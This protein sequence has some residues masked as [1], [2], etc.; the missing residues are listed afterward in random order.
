VH[1]P[2]FGEPQNLKPVNGRQRAEPVSSKRGVSQRGRRREK[3]AI[4]API[5]I[6]HC[7]FNQDANIVTDRNRTI[8]SKV[9]QIGEC[10]WGELV[11]LLPATVVA[12]GELM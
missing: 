9:R 1:K 4:L 11:G 3:R 2:K 12:S 5:H 8:G 7:P 6:S 10:L